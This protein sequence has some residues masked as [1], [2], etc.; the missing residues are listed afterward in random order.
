MALRVKTLF[1]AS[2]I[3]GSAPE[4]WDLSDAPDKHH[5][6]NARPEPG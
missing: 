5:L 1:A 6:A 3:R 4:S 2:G